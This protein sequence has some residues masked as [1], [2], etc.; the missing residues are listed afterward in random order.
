MWQDVTPASAEDL[1]CLTF[2]GASVTAERGIPSSR[3]ADSVRVRLD[4]RVRNGW[5]SIGL[6]TSLP[7]GRLS[8]C[9]RSQCLKLP[10]LPGIM[11][12]CSRHRLSWRLLFKF[13]VALTK[14][15]PK[16]LKVEK[17]RLATVSWRLSVV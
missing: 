17:N 6:A 5:S 12:Q 14:R 4:G 8:L 1:L 16:S 15:L 3:P 11:H 2:L 9:R 10:K 13:T 7:A